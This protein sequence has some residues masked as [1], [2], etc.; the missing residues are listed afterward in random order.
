MQHEDHTTLST[1]TLTKITAATACVANAT[2][3]IKVMIKIIMY[4][5]HITQ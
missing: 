3:E 2:I 5:T 4:S 1:E